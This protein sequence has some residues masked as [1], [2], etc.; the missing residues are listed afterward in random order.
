M[1]NIHDYLDEKGRFDA[2]YLLIRPLSTDGATADVWLALDLNT[3]AVTDEPKTKQVGYMTDEEIDKLG[4]MVAIKIY[5]P[6][7][8]LDIEGEQ[9]FRDEYMIVFNC[10]HANLI[11]PTNFSICKDAPYLV[12]PYCKRGSSEVL[13]GKEMSDDDVWKYIQDVSSGLAYLHELDPPIIH[14]DVK[15]ANVLIDDS[16]NFAITDF[17]I[18][19]Q[20]GGVHGYYFDDDNSG[21]MAY[22]APERFLD[23]T[24]P[25]PQSD[26]WGFGAT[27]C[28]VLT[29]NVPFGEE[30]GKAQSRGD[31]PMPAIPGVSADVQRLIHACLA[32]EPGDRPT[33]RQISEAARAR[34]YPVKSRKPLVY[35][36]LAIAALLIGGAW[37]FL[38]P[39]TSNVL[40]TSVVPPPQIKPEVPFDQAMRLMIAPEKVDSMQYAIDILDS[41][42]QKKKYIPAMFKMASMF[43]AK[44][45]PLNQNNSRAS[46]FGD[47]SYS[48]LT[49]ILALEDSSFANINAISAYRLTLF[50]SDTKSNLKIDYNKAYQYA[51]KAEKWASIGND[52]SIKRDTRD[53]DQDSTLVDDILAIKKYLSGK[54]KK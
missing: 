15:P 54:I 24:E 42:S 13:I 17:G 44:N 11:H 39:M 50:Y 9:R 36:I 41:L 22:M 12:L 49:Q 33:A 4:L 30:G 35:A 52:P 21:T 19:S 23:E 45:S 32:K 29:G 20:R 38:R 10:H 18:S 53:A 28:E 47:E 6:Q 27:L 37:Y 2:R 14:Q 7:N 51:C 46:R 16:G 5:R 40:P 31:V 43:S 25:M 8:A 1:I 26:M 3:V 48:L 34:Q